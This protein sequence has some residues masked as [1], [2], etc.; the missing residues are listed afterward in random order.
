M[1]D[2]DDSNI[3]HI[4]GHNVEPEE[5][6]EALEDPDLKKD[7]AYNFKGE[8]RS[9]II[10]ATEAGRILLVIYTRRGQNIRVVTVRDASDAQKR[11]YRR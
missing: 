3:N 7:S 8:R 10:G 4:A 5:A 1:F 6:E 9:A 2:W 11:R